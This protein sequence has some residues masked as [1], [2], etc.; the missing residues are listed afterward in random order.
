MRMYHT[1]RAFLT[2]RGYQL[3]Q[4]LLQLTHSVTLVGSV[5]CRVC[6]AGIRFRKNKFHARLFKVLRL[7]HS[8]IL[9]SMQTSKQHVGASG[10]CLFQWCPCA[11][12]GQ[13]TWRIDCH[14]WKLTSPVQFKSIIYHN[15]FIYLNIIQQTSLMYQPSLALHKLN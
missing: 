14:M 11:I 2:C 15:N 5:Y 8:R 12:L 3:T 6:Y 1:F 10:Q 13:I 9:S 4:S 7:G